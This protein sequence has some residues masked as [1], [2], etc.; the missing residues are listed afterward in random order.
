MKVRCAWC[1][2][3]IQEDLSNPDYAQISHGICQECIYNLEYHKIPLQDLIDSLQPPIFIINAEGKIETANK[4]AQIE[5]NKPISKIEGM[6][7]GDVIECAYATLPGGCGKT[8]HCTGCGIRNTVNY[9]FSTG[10][11]KHDVKVYQ[12]LQTPNGQKRVELTLNTEKVGNLV[13]LRIDGLS[14]IEYE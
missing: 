6:L 11:A 10:K 5:I 13:Y 8:E 4:T 3:I 7:G 14:K 1:G 2:K 12:Y 9:T